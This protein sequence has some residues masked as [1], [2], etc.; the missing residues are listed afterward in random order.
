MYNRQLDAFVKT[1][2]LGSFAKAAEAMYISSP[3]LLQQINLLE[4]RCG[5][6]LFL[7]SNHGVKLTAAGK[8]LY[9]D[10]KTII[11]LSGDALEKAARLAELSQNTVRVATSLLFKC[12][13][14]PDIWAKISERCPD[15][16]IEILPIPEK[17]SQIDSVQEIGQRY[18]IREGIYCDTVLDGTC[19]FLEFQRTR[20]CCAVSKNHRLAKTKSLTLED[21]NGECLVMP[22]AGVSSEMDQFRAEIQQ[23]HPTIHI[24][25]SPYYGVDTF[26]LCEMNPY[27]L[28]SQ[29][30]YA[31]IHP[32]LIS[33]PLE[34]R[35]AL[36]YGLMYANTPTPATAQFIDAVK[37]IR[38]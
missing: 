14:L 23:G 13:L 11:R 37:H 36:P 28:V 5:F 26:T 34:T 17:Q 30:V 27:V 29:E 18:D 16:K 3:A 8:S 31:D 32:N 25:D 10:A 22:I 4:G 9:E 6:K 24:I 19:Q 7:R 15:L 33:I 21:L 20:F 38:T 2:E 35:H 1:A 12:R